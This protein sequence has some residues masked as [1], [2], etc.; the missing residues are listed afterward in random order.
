VALKI[1]SPDITHK[2]EVGGVVLGLACGAAVEEAAATIS[3][4]LARRAPNAKSEGFLVGEMISGGVECIVG[5]DNDPVFGPVIMFGLGGILVELMQ[6]VTFRL[7]PVDEAQAL[8]MVES[9]RGFPLLDGYRGKP[10]ADVAT[11]ARAIS[12]LSHLAATNAERLRTFEI[13]PLMV[14]PKGRGVVALDAVIETKSVDSQ[15]R[16]HS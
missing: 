4:S 16:L 2:T 14:M 11:L 10:K 3:Q 15:G 1:L 8:A 9:V 13:N 6:D 5:V 7:A 12:R